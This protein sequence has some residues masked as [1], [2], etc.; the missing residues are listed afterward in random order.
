MTRIATVPTNWLQLEEQKLSGATMAALL[1]RS[2][3]ILGRVPTN[4]EIKDKLKKVYQPAQLVYMWDGQP[5]ANIQ[6]MTDRAEVHEIT[7]EYV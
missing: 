2:E 5:V 7:G 1:K 4:D 3:E 6:F